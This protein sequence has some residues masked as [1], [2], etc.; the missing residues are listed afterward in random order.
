MRCPRCEAANPGGAR[1]CEDC[2]TRLVQTCPHC[3]AEVSPGKSFCWSCGGQIADPAT[4]PVPPPVASP[5]ALLQ[6]WDTH[7]SW[8]GSTLTFT[9]GASLADGKAEAKGEINFNPTLGWARM[10]LALKDTKIQQLESVVW[11]NAP[12]EGSATGLAHLEVAL[13]SNPGFHRSDPVY[14][15]IPG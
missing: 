15:S 5:T 14:R 13:S 10:D 6:Q 2:G 1:F 4:D 9:E 3:R 11:G 7:F 12:V 8:Q